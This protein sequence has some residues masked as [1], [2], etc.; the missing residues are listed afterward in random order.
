M[1]KNHKK[2]QTVMV[3][4]KTKDF[5]Q[6][7]IHNKTSKILTSIFWNTCQSKII[8]GHTELRE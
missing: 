3:V 4:H 7:F 5:A 6:V 1:Y 8:L 2:E